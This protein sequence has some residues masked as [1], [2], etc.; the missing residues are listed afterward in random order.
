[1]RV[2][3]WP[4]GGPPARRDSTARSRPAAGAASA[5]AAGSA[6]FEPVAVA[7]RRA[8][9]AVLVSSGGHARPRRSR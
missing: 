6:T 5:R 4:R 7:G 2:G 9:T 8:R 3:R 1:M